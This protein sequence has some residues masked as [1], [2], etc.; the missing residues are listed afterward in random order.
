MPKSTKSTKFTA[1]EDHAIFEW[2]ALPVNRR[3]YFEGNRSQACRDLASH[4][5]T[6]CAANRTEHSVRR[7]LS[8]SKVDRYRT[9]PDA[10]MD[11]DDDTAHGKMAHTAHGNMAH[12]ANSRGSNDMAHGQMAHT[13]SLR[14]TAHGNMAH[15]ASNDGMAHAADS[16]GSNSTAHGN[17]AHAAD[18]RGSNSTVHINMAHTASPRG[19][20]DG[21]AHAADSHGSN[22]GMAHAADSRGS[23]M[24]HDDVVMEDDEW[25]I[26]DDVREA[27]WDIELLRTAQN[28]SITTMTKRLDTLRDTMTKEIQLG[29]VWAEIHHR[30]IE[31]RA[32]N[33][34]R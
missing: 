33:G 14:G 21:M 22:D 30:A 1:T 13:A 8:R 5:R 9:L 7:K 25:S 18:S 28:Y 27:P 4:L 32:G 24:A 6:K 10:S 31:L 34:R 20:N 29:R 11:I 17:M 12:T 19:S 16:R 15:T 3:K 2:F 23:N 26:P